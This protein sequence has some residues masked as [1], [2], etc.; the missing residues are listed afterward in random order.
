MVGEYV[1]PEIR[2]GKIYRNS[3]L[4]SFGM[5]INALFAN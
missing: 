1:P 3:D 4:Y 5:L 2:Q